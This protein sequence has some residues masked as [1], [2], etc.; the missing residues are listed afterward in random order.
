MN[1]LKKTILFALLTTSVASWAM[2]SIDMPPGDPKKL[3]IELVRQAES[4]IY[5]CK[6]R[7]ALFYK[8]ND[9]SKAIS[10]LSCNHYLQKMIDT[11]EDFRR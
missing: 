6:P 11:V 8:W 2:P 4:L 9:T 3:K 7:S 1:L 10:D 5:Y